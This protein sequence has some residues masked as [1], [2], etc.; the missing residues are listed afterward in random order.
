MYPFQA[1]GAGS[2]IIEKPKELIKQKEE[3]KTLVDRIAG[4]ESVYLIKTQIYLIT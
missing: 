3:M 4:K 1:H 2:Q